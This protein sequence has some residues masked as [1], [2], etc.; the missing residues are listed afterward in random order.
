[1]GTFGTI[2]DVGHAAGPILA[3][4]LIARHGYLYSFWYMAA[5]LVLAVPLFMM[6]VK[7]HDKED[8]L[9]NKE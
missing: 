7:V 3:G 1:M 2:F 9:T 8:R 4:F 5:A 6:T